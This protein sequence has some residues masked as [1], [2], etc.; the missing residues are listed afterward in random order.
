MADVHRALAYY[1]DHPEEMRTVQAARRTV[2][3]GLLDVRGPADLKST[4]EP[5]PKA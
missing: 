2:P 3:D 4:N 1:D 5:E